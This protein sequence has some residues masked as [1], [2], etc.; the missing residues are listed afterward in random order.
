MN[1]GISVLTWGNEVRSSQCARL[2][3][4]SG[5]CKIGHSR[6]IITPILY[7]ATLFNMDVVLAGGFGY[8]Y[9]AVRELEYSFPPIRRMGV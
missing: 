1:L 7:E 2:Y 6:H 9:W 5:T 8:A 3:S 4:F